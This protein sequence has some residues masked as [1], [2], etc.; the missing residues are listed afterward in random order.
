MK[1]FGLTLLLTVACVLAEPAYADDSMDK[2]CKQYVQ[3]FYDWYLKK[4]TGVHT[5]DPTTEALKNKKFA[6]SKELQSKLQEDHDVAQLFPGEIVGLDFDPFFNG[7]DMGSKYTVAYVK[8]VGSKYQAEVFAT[9]DGKQSKKPDVVPELT[10][11][12]AHWVFVNFLYPG[13]SIPEN[14]DL[15]SVLKQLKKDRPPLPNKSKA[16]GEAGSGAGSRAESGVR[17]GAKSN[18]HKN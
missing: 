17:A 5:Y 18:V 3:E 2:S 13:A 7:Q 11:E 1:I 8:R 9:F 6:F 10:Y 15:L 4:C 16:K 14:S 12:N